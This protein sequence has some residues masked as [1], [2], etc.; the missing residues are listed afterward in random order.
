MKKVF[1]NFASRVT[2]LL[3]MLCT[4]TV[5]SCGDDDDAPQY[6]GGG[7]SSYNNH[8]SLIGYWLGIEHDQEMIKTW[9]TNGEIDWNTRSDLWSTVSYRFIDDN[10]VEVFWAVTYN[11]SRSDALYT[12]YYGSHTY[13]ICKGSTIGTYAYVADVSKFVIE[14]GTTGKIFAGYIKKDGV[15]IKY[16]KIM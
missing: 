2:I 6:G 7:G 1:H 16:K 3:M 12:G 4:L 11:Y 13:S 14:D 9:T 10:T 8:S 15:N 5:I